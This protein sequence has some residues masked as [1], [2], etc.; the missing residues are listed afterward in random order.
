VN[1]LL[2]ARRRPLIYAIT[3]RN[4]LAAPNNLTALIDYIARLADSGIDLIQLRER[5]LP[6]RTVFDLTKSASTIAR[7]RNSILLVNDRSDI[8]ACVG[9]GVHLTARSLDARVV[10]GAFND[11]MSAEAP[12]TGKYEREKLGATVPRLIGSSTHS[13]DEALSAEDAGADFIVFGPVFETASKRAYGPPVGLP[14]LQR[15]VSRLSLPVLGIGGIDRNNFHEVLD[16]GADGIA[17][18]S[19]FT[20]TE[21]LNGLV[22][23]IKG[24]TN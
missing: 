18:I 21:Q 8:A 11:P 16:T 4:L 12:D 22:Q 5:D 7:S 10:R 6:A 14:A 23:E 17:G 3:D 20:N 15:V 19:L 24:T 1:K 9:T 2:A 13:L